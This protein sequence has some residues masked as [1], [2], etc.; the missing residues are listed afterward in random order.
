MNG[1]E[2]VGKISYS[3]VIDVSALKAGTKS[4]EQA[5]KTSFG[6]SEKAINN[7]TSNID[8]SLAS[9]ITQ[10]G[11]LTVSLV[12]LRKVGNFLGD[13]IDSANKFQSAML[14]L[15]SVATAF[16]GESDK[17]L[18]A[19]KQLSEDGLLPL[20]DAATGLKNLLAAGYGLEEATLLMNRFK[21]S[22]AFGRQ[23]S[24]SFGEAVRSATEGVK[25]GNSI[26]VDNAGVTKNLS[27]ILEEAGY[28]AQDLMKAST[29]V[30]V[31]MAILNGIV[32][33][34]NAQVGDAAKL[35]NTAAGADAQFE[36]A[37]NQLQVRL[38]DLS[39]MLRKDLV[40]SLAGFISTNQ[41]AI[42]SVGSGVV[43][44]GTVITVVP[45]VV[46]GIRTI[47]TTLK[48]LTVAQAVATGGLSL[49]ATALGVA[50]GFAVNSLFD[51]MT[52]TA[53]ETADAADS[54]GKMQK[55]IGGSSDEAKDLA[56][57]LKKID[58]QMQDARDNFRE[59]LAELVKDKNESI[60][61]LTQRL[62]D[63]ERAY[64]KSY[65]TRTNDFESTNL[66]ETAEH[67]K[68]TKALQNQIDF[69]TKYNK[70]SNAQQLAELQFAL[71][72]ENAAYAKQTELRQSEFD[73]QTS[74]EAQEY[75]QRRAENE[76][77]LNE[78]LALLEKHRDD[79]LAIRD[80]ILLD[81]IEKLKR[82][83]DEQLKSLEQ[84]RL[85]AIEKGTQ[86]GQG[87]AD[88]YN[89]A[90]APVLFNL[91]TAQQD[92][93]AKN[94]RKTVLPFLEAGLQAGVLGKTDEYRRAEALISGRGYATGGF[95][96]QGGVNETA[97]VV[98]KGEYVLPQS[99][100]NQAT[101]LPKPEAINTLGGGGGGQT[102][103][104][105]NH[106]SGVIVSSPQDERRLAEIVTKRQEESLQQRGFM[107]PVG[108]A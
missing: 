22:A 89:A 103:E 41:D 24:L 59:Q 71:A 6:N 8:R 36:Y 81:E 7:A 58:D 73:T 77:K 37:T 61:Q 72:K 78:E 68:K 63:E 70:S 38:G 43:A 11:L 80:V 95:T 40:G 74:F 92:A 52:G 33:E 67:Q 30:G 98:H 19:A 54:A 102:V 57:Q 90:A 14:G 94:F 29:D 82:S 44:F 39:N 56:K 105:H 93:V 42:L 86:T 101:G 4:A 12:A 2:E 62:A 96:G 34:T 60:A 75:E 108:A 47:I 15:D 48:A 55:S 16:T 97:G 3:V 28:S 1:N 13:S 26:L 20:A 45:L 104:I 65:A 25:N 10:L 50:A 100:V 31:R 69:L 88:A 9:T 46:R 99:M 21:D 66:R 79:V 32:R 49:L 107:K 18:D 23:N 35:T 53:E 106:I 64:Q 85:D 51:G 91:T 5:I 87:Y 27:V 76:K 83:R 17:A 84:Q